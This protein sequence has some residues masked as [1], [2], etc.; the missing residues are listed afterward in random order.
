MKE[1]FLLSALISLTIFTACNKQEMEADLVLANQ[2]LAA[3]PTNDVTENQDNSNTL[4]AGKANFTINHLG[5][6]VFEKDVLLLTNNSIN[7][8]SYQWDFGNGDT[9]TEAQPVYKYNSH[10]YYNVTLTITDVYGNTHQASDEV[11]VLCIFGGGDH[12]L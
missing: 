4:N 2:E 3:S 5:N 10:G 11:I 12:D 6:S 8:V 9:S 1:I 7:A